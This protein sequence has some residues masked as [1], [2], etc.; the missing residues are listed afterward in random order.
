M[1]LPVAINPS[2]DLPA[3]SYTEQVYAVTPTDLSEKHQANGDAAS[4]S[5]QAEG[6]GQDSDKYKN[7]YITGFRLL[8]IMV[9]VNLG[10]LIAAL[11]LGIVATAIPAITDDFHSLQD[12]GW[13]SGGVFLTIFLHLDL[14][15][16]AL[17]LSSVVCFSL[18]LQWGGLTEAWPNGSVVA[19]LVMWLVLTIALIRNEWWQRDYAMLPFRLRKP[20]FEW[21]N[22]LGAV[23][24]QISNFQFIFYLPLYFQ[25]IQGT[26]AIA[27]GVYHL[28][29]VAFFAVGEKTRLLQPV[30]LAGALFTTLGA[31]LLYG[32]SPNSSKAWYIGAQI[33][34]GFGVGLA[35][36]SF[37]KPEDL[38]STMGIMFMA[39]PVAGTYFVLAAQSVFSNRI[40]QTIL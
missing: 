32:L 29:T 8:I 5:I 33:P 16:F 39:Q 15:G 35:N 10:T 3:P 38:R 2:L 19:T 25:S 12:I 17:F 23:F 20:R 30:E 36:Q 31:G 24:S 28:P 9:T 18:A 4:P 22:L 21:A 7:E 14:L 13:Y 34:L 40:I 37:A 26:S 6:D 1:S 27:S 11:D